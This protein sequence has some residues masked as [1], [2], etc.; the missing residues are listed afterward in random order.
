MPFSLYLIFKAFIECFVNI[1]QCE[2]LWAIF[3]PPCIGPKFFSECVEIIMFYESI[4][5]WKGVSL[6][7]WIDLFYIY[8]NTN[9]NTLSNIITFLISKNVLNNIVNFSTWNG[10]RYLADVRISSWWNSNPPSE[11]R[12]KNDVIETFVYIL[13]KRYAMISPT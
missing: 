13:N 5:R 10:L 2:I 1:Y 8:Y 7:I 6:K 3:F 12:G 4:L 9:Y 11:I